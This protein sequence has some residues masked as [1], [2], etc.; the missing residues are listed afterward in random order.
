MI[1]SVRPAEDFVNTISQ[2]STKRISPNFCHRCTWVHVDV[3]TRFWVKV[4]TVKVTAGGDI[5]VD[6][7]TSTP[8]ELSRVGLGGVFTA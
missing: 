3:V 8:T 5:T 6:G 4:M 2:K 7:S 1:E